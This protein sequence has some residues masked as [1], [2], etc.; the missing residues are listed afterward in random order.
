MLGTVIAEQFCVGKIKRK[1]DEHPSARD[2]LGI[3]GE[4]FF[5]SVIV[6]AGA[7]QVAVLGSDS[8]F[9]N[10][11]EIVLK[12]GGDVSCRLQKTIYVREVD[13]AAIGALEYFKLIM[14]QRVGVWN[15]I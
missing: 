10:L 4:H 1:V 3:A 11:M 5:E 13:V 12:D 7:A 2:R 6:H 14:R 15:R 8:D 9:W